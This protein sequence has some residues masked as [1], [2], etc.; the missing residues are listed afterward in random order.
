MTVEEAVEEEEEEEV[1]EEAVE[2][3]E[4]AAAEA[5]R[6][7]QRSRSVIS[8]AARDFDDALA[9]AE[10]GPA[11]RLGEHLG[12][13]LP[14]PARSA[15]APR[16]DGTVDTSQLRAS[17]EQRLRAVVEAG[18]AVV[19]AEMAAEAAL[20][21]QRS[22]S[23][24]TLADADGRLV[25]QKTP[26]RIERRRS[27]P[28]LAKV[29]EAAAAVERQF[30]EEAETHRRQHRSRSVF[31]DTQSGAIDPQQLRARAEN[32]LAGVEAAAALT[33]A[34]M[35]A[36]DDDAAYQPKVTRTAFNLVLT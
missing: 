33:T 4:E 2:E 16:E 22:H 32:R 34:A 7:K 27:E 21:R 11:H 26:P 10:E 29:D 36:G 5:H 12:V 20:H 19:G 17:S 14:V 15:A 30:L 3:E 35:A 13:S 1:A 24:S 31:V 23:R 9:A 28:T 8:R 6:R 18:S 25:P